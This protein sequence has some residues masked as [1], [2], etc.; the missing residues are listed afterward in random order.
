MTGNYSRWNLSGALQACW[1]KIKGNSRKGKSKDFEIRLE[2]PKS[3]K[4]GEAPRSNGT[5]KT[6]EYF[7]VF[8][9]RV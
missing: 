5:Q 6:R 9:R 3:M 2:G 4:I 7:G 8:T 1:D